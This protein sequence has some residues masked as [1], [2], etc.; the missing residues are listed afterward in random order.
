MHGGHGFL[1]A[2]TVVLRVAPPTTIVFPWLRP[3]GVPRSIIPPLLA[4]PPPPRA[5][6]AP[7]PAP[8]TPLSERG[9]TLLMSSLGLDFSL[10]KL[11]GV[12]PRA[13]LTAVIECSIMVWLGFVAGRAFGWSSVESLFCGAIVA[14]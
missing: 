7:A 2:V 13:F 14:I 1:L 11:V 8:V 12:A 9:A 10:G 5:P 3:P 4:R 6:P